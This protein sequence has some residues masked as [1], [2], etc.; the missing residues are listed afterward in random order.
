MI[1]RSV[2][3]VD[4]LTWQEQLTGS[5]RDPKELLQFLELDSLELD[6]PE[7]DPS[8]LNQALSASQDFPLRVPVAYLHRITKGDINDPLL[9]QVLPLKKE[10]LLTVTLVLALIFL[11]SNLKNYKNNN[12]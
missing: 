10:L 5:I 11:T 9:L 8:L 2:A 4:S 12:L 7:A 6:T 3:S 1:T